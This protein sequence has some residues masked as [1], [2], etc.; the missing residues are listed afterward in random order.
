ME[1]K[2]GQENIFIFNLY[3]LGPLLEASFSALSEK[4]NIKLCF[5]TS[6]SPAGR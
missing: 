5:P 4:D 3:E 6:V 2:K 1:A